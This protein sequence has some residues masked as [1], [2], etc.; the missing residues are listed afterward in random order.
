MCRCNYFLHHLCKASL[1]VFKSSVWIKCFIIMALTFCTL[2]T[3]PCS[4]YFNHC[5]LEEHHCLHSHKRTHSVV[6]DCLFKAVT[7]ETL[8]LC[9]LV[10]WMCGNNSRQIPSLH[11]VSVTIVASLD[12]CNS[13]PP[14]F[15]QDRCSSSCLSLWC[16]APPPLLCHLEGDHYHLGDFTRTSPHWFNLPLLP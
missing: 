4:C 2:K 11:S 5:Y 6:E 10:T 8:F 3:D 13:L 14:I 7:L 15:H 9:Y 16:I 12:G 1:S